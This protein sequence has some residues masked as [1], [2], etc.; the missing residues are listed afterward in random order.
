MWTSDLLFRLWGSPYSLPHLQKTVQRF[1]NLSPLAP[2]RKNQERTHEL[3][4]YNRAMPLLM[5]TQII[6]L[7]RV[8]VWTRRMSETRAVFMPGKL[9]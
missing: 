4:T 3:D 9:E 5:I 1:E 7:E 8:A 2:T 6:F